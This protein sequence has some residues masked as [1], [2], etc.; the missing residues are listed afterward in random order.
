MEP[1][2]SLPHSQVPARYLSLSSASSIQPIHPHP[3]SWRS[4]LILSSHPRLGLPCGL[5]PSGFPTKT[6][7]TLTL[8]TI[9]ATCPAHSCN[10]FILHFVR[11]LYLMSMTYFRTYVVQFDHINFGVT[12][13]PTKN[14]CHQG[15]PNCATF[16]KKLC[17]SKAR[18]V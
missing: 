9:R 11:Y 3:T 10:N 14:V 16:Q 18:D 1:E 12:N 15:L 4:I 5:F 6:L 8:S 13:L 17:H 7:N 2:G